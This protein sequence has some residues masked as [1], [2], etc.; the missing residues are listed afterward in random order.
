MSR[1]NYQAKFVYVLAGVV[2]FTGLSLLFWFGR[3]Y[4]WFSSQAVSGENLIS[5]TSTKQ[6]CNFRRLLDGAC[7]ETSAQINPKLLAIM[8]ENHSEARPQSGLA[9][10]SVVY[11]VPVEANYT[12]FLAIYPADAKVEKVGPVRSA[13]PY[14]L[15]WVEEYGTPLYMHVGGSPDALQK[16]KLRD[17]FGLNQFFYGGYYWRATDRQAPHNVYT[18]SDLWNEAIQE[19]PEQGFITGFSGWRFVTSN[20][21]SLA[22]ELPNVQEIK[23]PFSPPVYQAV[24]KY[25]N[26]TSRY[27]RYQMGESHVDSD[28]EQIMADTV[29]VQ[30]VKGKILDEVGRLELTT[31]GQGKAIVFVKGKM[32]SGTWKKTEAHSRTRY[33]NESGSEISLVSGKIW[34][35]VTTDFRDVSWQ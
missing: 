19:Y 31:I 9:K 12:R 28:G 10:A 1:L 22:E 18:S 16:I 3:Q 8:I 7:V 20:T 17:I 15:D 2:F 23:I 29:I 27:G 26:D 21:S 32:I 4:F 24:W 25:N 11:E 14:Y 6:I 33:Y 5:T 30:E 35:E 34:I 13:R